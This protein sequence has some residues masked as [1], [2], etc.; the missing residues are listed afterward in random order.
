MLADIGA[1]LLKGGAGIDNVPLILAP[2]ASGRYSY[3]DENDLGYDVNQATKTAE[4][5][6]FGGNTEN[7]QDEIDKWVCDKSGTWTLQ[8]GYN[9]LHLVTKQKKDHFRQCIHRAYKK[10]LCEPTGRKAGTYRTINHDITPIDIFNTT[11]DYLNIEYP[12]ELHKWYR[13]LPGVVVIAGTPDA[14]KTAF[15]LHFCSMNMNRGVPIR[16]ISSDM[17][18]MEFKYRAK[19]FE[20]DIPLE[21]WR[22]VEIIEGDGEYEDL[23]IPDGINIIDYM[24][25][26]EDFY[27]VGKWLRGIRDKLSGSGFALVSLQKKFGMNLAYGAETTLKAPKMYITLEGNPPEGGIAKCEKVKG[28]REDG[29]SLYKREASF[30]IHNT[31]KMILTS[32]WEYKI[33]HKEF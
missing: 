8:I 12:L 6:F 3:E 4:L 33:K 11:D 22:K 15:S 9:E 17:T 29:K 7:L 18:P 24:E 20:P 28:R 25:C 21:Y 27:L 19:S 26:D 10:G 16:Y 23:I 2:C 13:T 30:R 31:T 14:G 32:E 1:W 5:R